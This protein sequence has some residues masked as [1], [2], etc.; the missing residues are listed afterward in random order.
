MDPV[1]RSRNTSLRLELPDF[2]G[3]PLD[4]HH[5][6]K[7]FTSALERAGSDFSD[8][9]KTCFLLK[10]MKNPEAEQI[11]R[12]YAAAEDGYQ[13]PLKTLILR[14]GAA[15][16][17]FTHLV[18]KMTSKDTISFNQ[19][20]FGRYRNQ[21]VLPLQ[22]I[23]ELGC[24]TISQFAAS[25]ALERF[26]KPLRD[27]WAKNYKTVDEVL[28]LE[29]LTIFLELLEHNLQS[30]MLDDQ[31]SISHSSTR[32]T[33]AAGPRVNSSACAICKEPHR[34]FKCPVFV[35]YD[36]TRRNRC[37]RDK[38]LCINC[39]GNGHM[40]NDCKSPYVCREC[41]GKHHTL[42]HRAP[43][44]PSTAVTWTTTNL[45][46]VDQPKT[47]VS[48]TELHSPPRVSFLSTVMVSARHGPRESG[49]S[50]SLVMEALASRLKLKCHPRCLTITRACGG[51]VS[52]H[53]VEI[54]LHSTLDESNVVTTKFNVVKCLPA[55]PA[56]LNRDQI[57]TE[58]HLQG[59]PLADPEFGGKLDFLIGGLDYD[60]CVLGSP[61]K[62]SHSDISIQ[63]TLFGWTVTGPLEQAS[64]S[65]SVLQMHTAP[66][67]LQQDLS[68]LWE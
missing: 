19:E 13:Q 60:A 32:K 12:S 16:K 63:P 65:A 30:L 17:V 42:L 9:E 34:I 51:L 24:T 56:P 64:P 61:T 55:A 7:L 62:G 44:P 57:K 28:F 20:G 58:P 18:H 5:F 59:L 45:M 23:M 46:A 27:E 50:S 52:K 14:F 49:A 25:L 67:D 41:R 68:F 66:D 39:L 47:E 15:K 31:P 54:S 29:D 11:V 1:R 40:S 36:T 3:H 33:F 48:A 38:K 21:F 8:R 26:D 43:N 35:G 6:Y 10:A 4:W 2:S 22:H 37:I 53:F